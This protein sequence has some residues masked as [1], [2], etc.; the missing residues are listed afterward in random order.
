MEQAISK[1]KDFWT[2][3]FIKQL[4]NYQNLKGQKTHTTNEKEGWEMSE[5]ESSISHVK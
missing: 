3:K 2:A 5:A 1:Y 4:Y